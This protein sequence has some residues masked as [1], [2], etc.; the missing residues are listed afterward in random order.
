MKLRLFRR[1]EQADSS[2]TRRYGGCGLGLSIAHKLSE[3]MAGEL[4]CKSELGGG[5]TF[6]LRLPLP[7]APAN[8]V[9]AAP[10]EDAVLDRKLG[11]C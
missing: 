2:V 6:T 9:E 1:F 5:S 7:D 8:L 3:M 11:T 10:K 4:D